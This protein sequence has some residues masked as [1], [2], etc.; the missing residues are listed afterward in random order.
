MLNYT[1]VGFSLLLQ[2][3]HFLALVVVTTTIL[4][5]FATSW[6]VVIGFWSAVM[7]SLSVLTFVILIAPNHCIGSN[8][9]PN[10]IL[11]FQR[12]I[13]VIRLGLLL[14]LLQSLIYYLLQDLG[15]TLHSTEES[16]NPPIIMNRS[17]STTL[18]NLLD[19]VFRDVVEIALRNVIQVRISKTSSVKYSK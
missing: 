1:Q 6:L 7:G 13:K 14:L 10:I 5:G 19:L 16:Y 3:V 9:I 4:V 12:N 17:V 8:V 11:D 15:L 18:Q 2:P